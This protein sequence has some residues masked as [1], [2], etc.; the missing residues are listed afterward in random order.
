MVVERISNEEVAMPDGTNN[1]RGRRRVFGGPESGPLGDDHSPEAIQAE[2]DDPSDPA[3]RDALGLDTPY[4]DGATHAANV[5]GPVEEPAT[6]EAE[7]YGQPKV[8]RSVGVNPAHA[9][10]YALGLYTQLQASLID[11]ANDGYGMGC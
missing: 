5:M 2:F 6:V 11:A 1:E 7:M 9:A 4:S 3:T 8:G 10:V